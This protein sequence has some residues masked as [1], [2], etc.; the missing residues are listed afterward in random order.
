MRNH[1]VREPQ[2]S[3]AVEPLEREI[4][5]DHMRCEVA[6]GKPQIGFRVHAAQFDVERRTAE[7]CFDQR[8]IAGD[9][10]D[11]EHAYPIDGHIRCT[12]IHLATVPHGNTP[13]FCTGTWQMSAADAFS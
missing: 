2:R 7:V 5:H 10:L 3:E 6:N 4:R 9:I 12:I 13:A 8:R 1:L 11:Q